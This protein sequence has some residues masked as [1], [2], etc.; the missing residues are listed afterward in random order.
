MSKCS[1]LTCVYQLYLLKNY[2]NN[3]YFFFFFLNILFKLMIATK[4]MGKTE[5]VEY[6]LCPPVDDRREES[7]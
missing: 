4:A 5:F 7:L 3:K 1:L 6:R 2:Y